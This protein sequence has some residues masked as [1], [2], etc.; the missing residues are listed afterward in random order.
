MTCFRATNNGDVIVE[1][2]RS[3]K[4]LTLYCP[5]MPKV[6][7][8]IGPA[9]IHRSRDVKRDTILVLFHEYKGKTACA[10]DDP[11]PPTPRREET[12]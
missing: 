9:D 5:Q 8:E 11:N 4:Q 12:K 3:G 6:W 7:S 1:L 10:V 2:K